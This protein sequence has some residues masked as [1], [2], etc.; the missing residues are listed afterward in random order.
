M[1]I[2]YSS[3]PHDTVGYFPLPNGKV[4][5]FLH[6]N[7]TIEQDEDGNDVY[8]AEEVYFQTDASVTKEHIEKN[9]ELMWNKEENPPV[10]PTVEE[11]LAIAED[12]INFLLGL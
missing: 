7:E 10:E 4:D 6:R 5:I 2:S 3:K 11:R 12:T 1:Q 9:F 8:V